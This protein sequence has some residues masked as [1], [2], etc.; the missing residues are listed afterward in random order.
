MCG[1]TL[2]NQFSLDYRPPQN[3]ILVVNKITNLIAIYTSQSPYEQLFDIHPKLP[4][5]EF[6]NC[7]FRQR[8]MREISPQQHQ[9]SNFSDMA[10]LS[11][12]FFFLNLPTSL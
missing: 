10:T 6:R 5:L 1:M 7:G 4:K 12:I 3:W 9:M 11:A 8:C 2:T